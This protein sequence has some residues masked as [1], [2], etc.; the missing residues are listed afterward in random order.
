MKNFDLIRIERASNLSVNTG[1][2]KKM[3]LFMNQKNREY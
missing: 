3:L 2:T 1:K